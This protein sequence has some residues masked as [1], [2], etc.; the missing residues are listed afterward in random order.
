MESRPPTSINCRL[1]QQYP[2]EAVFRAEGCRG[3]CTFRHYAAPPFSPSFEIHS[4]RSALGRNVV[5]GCSPVFSPI[6]APTVVSRV[7]L[8]DVSKIRRGWNNNPPE[9][10]RQTRVTRPLGATTNS[11]CKKRG[12]CSQTSR[13]LRHARGMVSG[14]DSRVWAARRTAALAAPKPS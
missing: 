3:G 8:A 9:V 4:N 6:K 7:N 5:R 14:R 1:N 2:P 12:F 13:G 10:S 11:Y